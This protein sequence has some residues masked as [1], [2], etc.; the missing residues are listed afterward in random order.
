MDRRDDSVQNL[1][2]ERGYENEKQIKQKLKLQCQWQSHVPLFYA[3]E[4]ERQLESGQFS[5]LTD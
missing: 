3:Q 4:R 2:T 1:I 5:E